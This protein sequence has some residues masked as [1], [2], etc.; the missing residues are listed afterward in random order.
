M[1]VLIPI[2]GTR[3]SV[4]NIISVRTCLKV[5]SL[6]SHS[7]SFAKVMKLPPPVSFEKEKKGISQVSSCSL[8]YGTDL[9]PPKDLTSFRRLLITPLPSSLPP[10]AIEL[11]KIYDRY[12]TTSLSR[13]KNLC[14]VC[15]SEYFKFNRN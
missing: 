12:S 7:R 14:K 8:D 6:A 2:P 3:I 4:F 10:S 13:R 5:G 9:F 15:S 1:F 11:I